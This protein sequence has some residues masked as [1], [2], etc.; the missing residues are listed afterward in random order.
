MKNKTFKKII[1]FV[2]VKIFLLFLL[3]FNTPIF[4]Q[5]LAE[6][7]SKFLGAGI[8][9]SFPSNFDLYWNQV[10]P[11]NAGKWGSV[12]S[13]RDVYQWN[14]L[15]DAYFYALDREFPFKLHTLIWGQQQPAWINALDSAAQA[16]EIEEWIQLA[17]EMYPDANFVDVVNE[18]LLF[19]GAQPSYKNAMGGDGITGWDWV[20]WAFEK[21][22]QYFPDGT[23]LILNEYHILNS[24]YYTGLLLG[25]VN[26]LQERNLID[27]IGIEGHHFEL[28]SASVEY[29]RNNLDRLAATGLSIYISEFD[30]DLAD[31]NA[32]LQEYQRLFPFLWEDLHSSHS[33]S[34]LALIL[35]ILSID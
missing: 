22:R 11:G 20:I 1:L 34:S 21:A 31:D 29:M 27:A 12:E 7:N 10:T 25:L 13:I 4:S 2:V 33:S 18:P 6:G 5:P 32:Q 3:L 16:E 23:K 8:D 15:D 26:L 24:S 30:I 14:A 17:A 35:K 9:G 28:S 19:H